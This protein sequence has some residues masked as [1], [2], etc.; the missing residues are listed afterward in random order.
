MNLEEEGE[1]SRTW[2]EKHPG[3]DSCWCMDRGSQLGAGM[4]GRQA[5][6]PEAGPAGNH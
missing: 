1:E 3:P 5:R 2:A 4:G 6:E